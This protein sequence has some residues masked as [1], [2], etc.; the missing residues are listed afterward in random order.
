MPTFVT[1]NADNRP[2]IDDKWLDAVIINDNVERV[3]NWL[4]VEKKCAQG[5]KQKE[6]DLLQG[7]QEMAGMLEEIKKSTK[8]KEKEEKIWREAEA[9]KT[10][11]M[12]ARIERLEELLNESGRKRFEDSQGHNA[13]SGNHNTPGIQAQGGSNINDLEHTQNTCW[14]GQKFRENTLSLNTENVRQ[15]TK[16]VPKIKAV[17][18][19][20]ENTETKRQIAEVYY[21]GQHR[22]TNNRDIQQRPTEPSLDTTVTTEEF[23][24]T[25]IKDKSTEEM[26]PQERDEE[27]YRWTDVVKKRPY[28]RPEANYVDFQSSV[29]A[30]VRGAKCYV[31]RCDRSS[32]S[33]SIK[34]HVISV[35]KKNLGHDVDCVVTELKN[36]RKMAGLGRIKLLCLFILSH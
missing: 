13:W 10:L 15:S 27:P 30:S 32:S 20:A 26:N 2:P 1:A 14:Q 8:Q 19:H 36:W 34:E 21:D 16:D 6:K 11:E 24:G 31:G 3:R 33:E 25:I 28:R 4:E 17:G 18:K 7:I 29:K 22:N 9:W 5:A 12:K 35:V 23:S